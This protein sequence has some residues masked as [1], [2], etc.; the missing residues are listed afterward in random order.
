VIIMIRLVDCRRMAVIKTLMQNPFYYCMLK[1]VT[2]RGHNFRK[3]L[4]CRDF[5]DLQSD[6]EKLAVYFSH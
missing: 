2:E 1:Q 5:I 4:R 6:Y 3:A